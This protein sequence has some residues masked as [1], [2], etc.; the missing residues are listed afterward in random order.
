MDEAGKMGAKATREKRLVALLE[1]G[2]KTE[3]M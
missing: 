3:D 2:K 1:S